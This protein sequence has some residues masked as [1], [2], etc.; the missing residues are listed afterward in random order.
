MALVRF[1]LFIAILTIGTTANAQEGATRAGTLRNNQ[2]LGSNNGHPVGP[3]SHTSGGDS[4]SHRTG[5]EDSITISY[6]YFDS[7][8]S[9][10]LDSN[11]LSLVKRI[12]VPFD[13]LF[14]GNLGSA[15][16]PVL[17]TPRMN[18]GFDA[19]FH[20]YDVYQYKLE[21]TR[22]FQ[23]TRPY[24][25]LGYVIAARAEQTISILYTQNINPTW[26][27]SFDFRFET[28]PGMLKNLQNSNRGLR[29][30]TSFKTK[31]L[32]YSG[33][34]VWIGNKVSAGESGGI[35]STSYLSDDR[36]KDR[37]L[38]PTKL[39]GDAQFNAN[40]FA[41][42]SVTGAFD[43]NSILYLRHQ[44]DFGQK[45]SIVTDSTVIKLFYPRIRLQHN[46]ALGN[47]TNSFRDAVSVDSIRKYYGYTSLG[48]S[49][50][51]KDVWKEFKNEFALIL[52]PE[53]QNQN[54]FLKLGAAYQILTG[55]LDNTTLR[56]N[57]LYL[58]GEYRNRTRNKKWDV[59][60]NGQ[61]YVAGYN[62]GDYTAR[63]QLQ[64]ALG[65][66]FGDLVLAF[67]N[68][69][70]TPSFVFDTR[71][72][73]PLL[74]SNASF[75]KEN[76]THLFASVHETKYD[77]ALSANY[78]VIANYSYFDSFYHATQ[79]SGITS[80]LHLG[81]EK[82]F[83]LSKRWNLY[84]EI[85][86]QQSTGNVINLPI[87]YTRQRL[88]FEG[89]F[90]KNLDMATG[91]DIRYFSPFKADNYSP[92]T[93]QFFLQEATT[94]R[95]RPDIAAFFHF[96]I[97]SFNCFIRAENLNTLTFSPQTGFL[98]NNFA[99][100]LY[101]TPGFFLRFGFKWGFVN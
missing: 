75:N 64:A 7:S 40:F 69:N 39:G 41:N 49:I 50:N 1:L 97:K 27:A 17:F 32:R 52:F 53:K 25:E 48:T 71:S 88:V 38:V 87:L 30:A 13:N 18:A 80:V 16:R 22:F 14:L 29:V 99:A 58:L 20:A 47:S 63:V 92:L 31:K 19:G 77:I 67:Q 101:P 93:Q 54:Q 91:L 100:P 15:A 98:K 96:R 62:A 12:P 4:L 65:K 44:Y 60:A 81:A 94:I 43:K 74:P 11:V 34:M 55:T 89:N 28:S 85:H 3:N 33:Y 72:S 45:D 10:F 73:F 36:Y 90:F 42:S 26:N 61:L 66:R 56:L 35:L 57:N 70:H 9:R 76:I 59:N 24:A 68:T 23:T 21:D 84:S 2:Q 78:Y 51:F 86:F 5:L 6:R 95:N 82:K 8:R 83:K 37:F 46:M 79:A